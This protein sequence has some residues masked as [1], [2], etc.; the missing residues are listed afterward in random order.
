MVNNHQS[1]NCKPRLSC[2][3]FSNLI[4]LCY[5]SKY[6]R[7]QG[8]LQE[9][10]FYIRDNGEVDNIRRSPYLL[11]Y[12]TRISTTSYTMNVQWNWRLNHYQPAIPEKYHSFIAFDIVTCALIT[13]EIA[14]F[15]SYFLHTM[16]E[17]QFPF[18][19]MIVPTCIRQFHDTYLPYSLVHA[20][21][22]IQYYYLN[23][24]MVSTVWLVIFA[25]TNFCK[26]SQKL[27]FKN[28]HRCNFRSLWILDPLVS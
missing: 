23:T 15:S 10:S 27:G 6:T 21:V 8:S 1:G 12:V 18:I 26:T 2:S 11:P 24:W 20:M 28:F 9:T 3:T 16:F 13:I 22:L 7:Q 5:F 19:I 4:G 17:S 25:C 14:K